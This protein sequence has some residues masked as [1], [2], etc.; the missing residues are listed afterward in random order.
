MRSKNP[1]QKNMHWIFFVSATFWGGQ[2]YIWYR[3]YKGGLT[4]WKKKSEEGVR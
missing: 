1:M 4:G 3:N 2:G